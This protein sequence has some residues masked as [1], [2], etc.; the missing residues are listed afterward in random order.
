MPGD[1]AER[2]NNDERKRLSKLVGWSVTS[3]PKNATSEDYAAFET[4]IHDMVNGSTFFKKIKK[5]FN[6]VRAIS[7]FKE[8]VTHDDFDTMM[9]GNPNS[10][11]ENFCSAHDVLR[12]QGQSSAAT[13]TLTPAQTRGRI[14]QEK[15]RILSFERATSNL[16]VQRSMLSLE[17]EEQGDSL[18]R[19]SS[20]SVGRPV[21]ASSATSANDLSAGLDRQRPASEEKDEVTFG[22]TGS[23]VRSVF[24]QSQSDTPTGGGTIPMAR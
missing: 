17:P 13:P 21:T 12:R 10:T 22:T 8:V 14:A 16:E 4:F 23:S 3:L 7:K 19:A 18:M 15:F 2:R 5:E 1:E 20:N 24:D 6:E 9:A 11:K